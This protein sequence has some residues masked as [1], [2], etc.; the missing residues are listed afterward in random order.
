MIDLVEIKVSA[1]SGGLGCTSFSPGRYRFSG[2]PD[3]GNGGS[4]GSV[5]LVGDGNLS[6]L[7]DF[8]VKSYFQA[9]SGRNGGT[10][11]KVGRGRHD[12]I[13]KIPLG[14]TVSD[15]GSGDMLVDIKAEG[16]SF[17]LACG[18]CGGKGNKHLPKQ[19]RLRGEFPSL[20]KLGE[21]KRLLL[22]VS[23]IADVGLVGLPNAGKT[24]LLNA[25]TSAHGEIGSYPFTTL[26]PNLGVTEDG[27]VLADIPG[28]IAGASEGKGLGDDFLRHVKRTR[29]LVHVLAIEVGV[30]AGQEKN[31]WDNYCLVREE[32]AKY[33]DSLTRKEELV[34]INK[35]DTITDEAVPL[36]CK[37][38][39]QKNGSRVF[40]VSALTGAGILPLQ[41]AINSLVTE[42]SRIP[43]E[44]LKEAPT[45]GISDLRQV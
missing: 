17:L 10:N 45:F 31:L 20:P 26:A 19:M 40:L 30:S 43:T 8:H 16:Q 32:L 36:A 24:T 34:V 2:A 4:G 22:E 12:L 28:L 38:L 44:V 27:V 42:N 15:V 18:G 5:Y 6:T 35:V 14:T 33:S 23:L 29:A 39:F 1:G 37:K 13:L 3:G 11:N 21:T 25:L 41:K 9:D 7:I